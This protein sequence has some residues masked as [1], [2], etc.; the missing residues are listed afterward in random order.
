MEEQNLQIGGM[1][2][3][4]KVVGGHAWGGQAGQEKRKFT[5]EIQTP[6]VTLE[7]DRCIVN[8]T[9]MNFFNPDAG[10]NHRWGI[11]IE[12]KQVVGDSDKPKSIE[13]T[14]TLV[15][16]GGARVAI[17]SAQIWGMAFRGVGTQ[18]MLDEE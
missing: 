13:V 17:T 6:F 1:F 16:H 9:L 18:A 7:K 2:I 3:F 8:G 12:D 11:Q 15:T 10:S 4:N 14:Y 5:V